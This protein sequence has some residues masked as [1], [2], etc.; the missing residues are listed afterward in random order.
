MPVTDEELLSEFIRVGAAFD[1]A[2]EGEGCGGSPGEWA[3]ERCVEL[4]A[5]IK[6]R[7]LAV[8]TN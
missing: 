4:E 1:S 6:R 3:Y 8:P 2:R 7:G 5:E